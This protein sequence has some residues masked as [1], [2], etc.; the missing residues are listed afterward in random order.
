MSN[1]D[2]SEMSIEAKLGDLMMKGWTMLADTCFKESCRSPLMRDNVSKQVYC[3]GCEAWVCNKKKT[4]DHHKFNEM[5]SLEGKQNIK[6]KDHT[7]ISTLP[8]KQNVESASFREILEKKL[9]VFSQSLEVETDITKCNQIL[10]AIKKTIE[11]L[12]DTVS[13]SKQSIKHN[14][15]Q[16]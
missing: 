7:E 11:L 14:I 13:N 3:V 12:H 2:E 6:L 10:E 16:K 15:N 1:F 9:I 8:K 5:V 4:Q